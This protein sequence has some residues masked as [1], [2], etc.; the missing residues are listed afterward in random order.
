ME[1]EH[2][3]SINEIIE[4]LKTDWADWDDKENGELHIRKRELMNALFEIET[5][6]IAYTGKIAEMIARG[7]GLKETH[8]A[9]GHL[10][11]NG[12]GEQYAGHDPCDM[13]LRDLK[14]K[15]LKLS[16]LLS[17]EDL[18]RIYIG[19]PVYK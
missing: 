18:K 8:W 11:L 13:C 5:A 7:E 1:D 2:R 17:Y 10:Q 14:L 19:L 3:M 12:P 4:K 6:L 9:C 15:L 16:R